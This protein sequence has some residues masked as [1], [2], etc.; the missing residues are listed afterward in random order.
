MKKR[1]I[2]L[3]AQNRERKLEAVA[4]PR[5]M[6]GAVYAPKKKP[7]RLSRGSF[8]ISCVFVAFI[9]AVFWFTTR[10]RDNRSATPAL[11]PVTEVITPQVV[12]PQKP[13]I[14]EVAP[15]P[16]PTPAPA[17][18]PLPILDSTDMAIP[19]TPQAP[20]A[21]WDAFHEEACEEASSLMVAHYFN[22]TAIGTS[23]QVEQELSDGAT[24][25]R[26]N[27]GTDVSVPTADV[28]KMLEKHFKLS[29]HALKNPTVAELKQ[30]LSDNHPII[31]PAAGQQ[32]H[33]PFFTQP[34]PRYHMLV[35]RGY[36]ASGNLVTNDPG[37]RHGEKYQYDPKTL[38]AATHD[39]NGGAVESG[40]KVMIVVTGLL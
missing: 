13:Q 26:A 37:T 28:V 5:Y 17:P 40:A 22:H 25:E 38:L 20:T 39:W 27:V 1:F 3:L 24:W 16:T 11:I 31:V 6:R 18:A 35:L 2:I 21:N 32:L 8:I 19:F 7:S 29:A 36:D 34:G 14:T 30:E 10:A 15:I 12:P 33:N 23:A 9:V 4:S